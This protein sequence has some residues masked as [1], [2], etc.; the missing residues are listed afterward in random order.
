MSG[1]R[2]QAG[3]SL[4]EVLIVMTLSLVVLGATLTTF[5]GFTRNQQ[6]SNDLN[7]QVEQARNG[8]D[9]MSRQL[10]NLAR[11][12]ATIGGFGTTP[13]INRAES[14]DF[15]F[16]TSAPQRTW[17]RYCLAT[18]GTAGG[19]AITADRSVLYEASSATNTV[20][21]GMSGICP[22]TGWTATRVV[23]DALV[24]KTGGRDRPLF[25]Y[26]CS[27]PSSCVSSGVAAD[28]L[29]V[30]AVR[31]DTYVDLNV[32]KKPTA[33]RVSTAVYLRNQN[34]PPVAEGTWK[35][36]SAGSVSLNASGS[37]DPEGRTL[38]YFWFVGST[39][40]GWS[41]GQAVPSSATYLQGITATLTG[42][43][44][45]TKAIY[46][47]VCDPGALGAQYGPM[48]VSLP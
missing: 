25:K 14:Y 45:T 10:R 23:G 6:G 26:T 2:R 40:A 37:E 27:G 21:A 33:Q 22:G 38:G 8:L 42:T 13:S 19:R 7:E 18:S 12:G 11:P 46:L 29:K 43:S 20:T 16:Q 36:G 28:L 24:N 39:P 35:P 32:N 5:A 4:P 1:H 15:I 44:G 31:S 47:V 3:Y 17:V 48:N 9:V 30:K 34:E 41:C